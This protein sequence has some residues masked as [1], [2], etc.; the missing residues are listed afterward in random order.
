MQIWL[1]SKGSR[2]L[3]FPNKASYCFVQQ[4]FTKETVRGEYEYEYA[5][6]DCAREVRLFLSGTVCH[7]KN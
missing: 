2:F 6:L 1:L 5:R 7:K 3:S 4:Y